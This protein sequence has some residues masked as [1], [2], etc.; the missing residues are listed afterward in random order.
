VQRLPGEGMRWLNVGGEETV[1]G[2]GEGVPWLRLMGWGSLFLL[3]E[4][5]RGVGFFVLC[6]LGAAWGG[7]SS[8]IHWSW[9]LEW[10]LVNGGF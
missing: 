3:E 6:L 10:E 4:W 1:I 8:Y 9:E 2:G 7:D 5:D